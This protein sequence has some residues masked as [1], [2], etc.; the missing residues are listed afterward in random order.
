MIRRRQA[1]DRHQAPDPSALDPHRLRIAVAA[2]ERAE[3]E[4]PADAALRACLRQHRH[5]GA[6]DRAWISRIVYAYYRWRGLLV[7]ELPFERALRQAQEL[8]E[9]FA[10]EPGA[11]SD[12][13][14]LRHVIP[15]WT[16]GH[17]AVT[18][19]WV[20]ALQREPRLWLRAQSGKQSIVAAALGDCHPFSQ[21]V[22][23]TALAYSG[24]ANVFHSAAYRDGWFEVQDLSSQA[25]GWIC[26]PRPG[27]TWW[28]VCA[29]EG[30]KTLHLSDRMGNR[31]LIWATDRALWRLRRLRLRAARARAFNCRI[32]PWTGGLSLPFRTRFDGVLVDAPCSGLGTWHRNP[33][34][35]WTT[36]EH[37][38]QELALAQSV[39]LHRAS[40]LVKPGG[41]LVYSVCT[42]TRAETLGITDLFNRDHPE[43]IPCATPNPFYP[44]RAAAPTHFFWPQEFGGNGM[45]TAVWRKVGPCSS[46]G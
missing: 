2:L 12:P 19:A 1:S 9:R 38:V 31:G 26:D 4:P 15:Q 16:A 36:R 6:A 37:D 30:G 39:L 17:V 32:R 21:G 46:E 28:D 20:R 13:I 3:R 18:G 11:F 10:A 40:A 44:E 41:T 8:D 14:L 23:D 22:L 25:V 43:F 5:L 34:A 29:G 45:F 35:R 24:S 27:E 7:G 42:L 33:Q